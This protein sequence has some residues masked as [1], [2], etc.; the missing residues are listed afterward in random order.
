[1]KTNLD[2]ILVMPV[3][4][5]EKIIKKVIETW[6]KTLNNIKFKI[7]LIND[8][9]S[10][11]TKKIINS[12]RSN[13]I[14]LLNKKNSGHGPTIV[15]G[16]KS[17]LRFKPN[18]IFQVD[19]DNQFFASD[20]KNFW[21]IRETYDF[22]LGYRLKRYDEPHRLILTKFLK[23]IILVIFGQNIKDINVPYRLFKYQC[24]F[25]CMRNIHND[26]IIPNIL[27]SLLC[28][29]KFKC[30]TSIVKHKKRQTGLVWITNFK[31][32]KFCLNAF[33][34]LTIF[35]MFKFSKF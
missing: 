13:K 9:S 11:D 25:G 15:H 7:I 33:I 28:S 10:D 20:F 19:S 8:G 14:L 32:L 18:F 30:H 35:R 34:E 6:L 16:Y 27:I 4:N 24:L 1:M 22:T 3:Y 29:K 12:I 5:E 21:K 2:L 23:F 31:L 26:S 17:A